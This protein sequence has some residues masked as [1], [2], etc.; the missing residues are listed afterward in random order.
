M[1]ASNGDLEVRQ[2]FEA[3]LG[4]N[5][6]TIEVT[7]VGSQLSFASQLRLLVRC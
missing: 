5:A 2:I 4:L 3:L 1:T 6:F 7:A